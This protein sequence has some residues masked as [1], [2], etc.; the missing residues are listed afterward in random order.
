MSAPFETSCME[1]L[2]SDTFPQNVFIELPLHRACR[3]LHRVARRAGEDARRHPVRSPRSSSGS[4][5]RDLTSVQVILVERT[6]TH[7]VRTAPFLLHF[8]A[9]QIMTG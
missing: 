2:A 3:A 5:R 9:S 1:T 6:H 8:G 4:Q 7:F